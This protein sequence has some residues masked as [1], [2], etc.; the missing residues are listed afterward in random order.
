MD[1]LYSGLVI[2]HL[3]GAVLGVGGA[4]F[5][6]II[7]GKSLADGKID[8]IEGG[9]LKATYK[10]VRV[11]LVIS[12]ITGVGFVLL[13]ILT[14]QHFKLLN[15]VLWAKLTI[16][17]I[18]SINALLLQMHKISLFWGSSFS[19]FSWWSV[20]IISTFLGGAAPFSYIEIMIGYA[21][22]VGGGVDS[23]LQRRWVA[24]CEQVIGLLLCCGSRILSPSEYGGVNSRPSQRVLDFL[25]RGETSVRS[26][27]QC[28][29]F[30]RR[31]KAPKPR[32]S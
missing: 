10:V 4:T 11:G 28:R 2:T 21:V 24:R 19:F 12:L 14:G 15:P 8:P 26:T 18:L 30:M 23:E 13:Y 16:I 25:L 27:R 6:E 9:F 31:L 3:I 22:A 5:I 29:V 17:I 20:L 32:C 1:P 7:L